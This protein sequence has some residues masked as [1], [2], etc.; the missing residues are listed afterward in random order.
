MH[1]K[2][3]GFKAF[4]ISSATAATSM[5]ICSKITQ[6]ETAVKNLNTLQSYPDHIRMQLAMTQT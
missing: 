6:I 3:N 1:K 4:C 2:K 5:H